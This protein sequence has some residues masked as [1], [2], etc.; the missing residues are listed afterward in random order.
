MSGSK[1]F[2]LLVALALAVGA[3]A[4]DRIGAGREPG[5]RD[6]LAIELPPEVQ[7]GLEESGQRARQGAQRARE[8]IGEA[9]EETGE[10]IEAAGEDMQN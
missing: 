3:T 9:V 1:E 6:T 8:R 2:A 7:E 4:C 10:R 5:D